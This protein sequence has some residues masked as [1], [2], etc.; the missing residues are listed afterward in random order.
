MNIRATECPLC[1]ETGLCLDL[2]RDSEP[3]PLGTYHKGRIEA[4][5]RRENNLQERE[6]YESPQF[7]ELERESHQLS[8]SWRTS[9]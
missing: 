5:R 1:R 6:E 8:P 4:A 2:S 9:R 7:H 3:L